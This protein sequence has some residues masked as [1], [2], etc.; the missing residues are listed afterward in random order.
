MSA[1]VVKETKAAEVPVESS[2]ERVSQIVET[3]VFPDTTDPI[4]Y[5]NDVSSQP[6][7]CKT[8]SQ[9][10]KL[11]WAS[12][13]VDRNLPATEVMVFLFR[14]CARAVVFYDNNPGN[15]LFTYAM[16]GSYA[17]NPGGV[18]FAALPPFATASSAYIPHGTTLYPAMADGYAGWWCDNDGVG[19]SHLQ[20]TFNLPATLVGGYIQWM[21]WN[22]QG[23]A[24]AEQTALV[25][26]TATYNGTVV[27]T[28]G[29]YMHARITNA[30]TAT[31]TQ[32]TL[33]LVSTTACSVWCHRPVSNLDTLL[34]I[35]QGVRT[36]T[37]SV[38]WNNYSSELD[39]SGKTVAVSCP[40]GLPWST[41][42]SSQSNLTS[43]AGYKSLLAKQ[44]YY[45]F[46]RI[47]DT[48]DLDFDL[49]VGIRPFRASTQGFATYDLRSSKSYI[50][51]C[52]SVASTSARDTSITVT[53]AVEYRTTSK[54]QEVRKP[55]I[56]GVEGYSAYEWSQAIQ[57]L[58]D[59]PQHNVSS[60]TWRQIVEQQSNKRARI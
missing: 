14:E 53:H 57:K 32:Y 55:Y 60:V 31:A 24:V 30:S 17:C 46:L 15:L 7:A 52:M 1:R 18:A 35:V 37:A 19:N 54:I 25:N 42:A 5:N 44:G 10:F 47:D 50:A 56:P 33:S 23:W 4:R 58:A 34:N 3:L 9:D 6:T 41:I 39:E 36:L 20:V 38:L 2:S 13:T 22:G 8:L 21:Q 45:G 40:P 26:G 59:I 49:D 12:A 27:G 51:V 48:A 43:L 11:N 29:A 16:A 28:G